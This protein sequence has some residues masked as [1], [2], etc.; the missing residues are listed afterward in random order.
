VKIES[1]DGRGTIW[2]EDMPLWA[3]LVDCFPMRPPTAKVE[4]D[5]HIFSNTYRTP[6][7]IW[8]LARDI[9]EEEFLP[10]YLRTYQGKV[11]AAIHSVNDGK[12]E[13]EFE[14][15]E[16]TTRDSQI[17]IQSVKSVMSKKYE[18]KTKDEKSGWKG[19]GPKSEEFVYAK[20]DA[21]AKKWNVVGKG[22][23]H[24]AF[25]RTVVDTDGQNKEAVKVCCYGETGKI[26]GEISKT[27]CAGSIVDK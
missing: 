16:K 12:S 18:D 3:W 7:K 21:A 23:S 19:E 27:A 22:T 10:I 5:C 2:V 13:R 1:K 9:G 6:N 15:V 20:R 14:S 26:E 17:D 25:S 4:L 11:N 24:R 8:K